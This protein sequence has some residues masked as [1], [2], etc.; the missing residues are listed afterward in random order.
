MSITLVPPTPPQ[1][2]VAKKKRTRAFKIPLLTEMS[3][4]AQ[5][6]YVEQAH[7]EILA[8]RLPTHSELTVKK[9]LLLLPQLKL[10]EP[11]HGS[12][13]LWPTALESELQIMG[14]QLAPPRLR[15]IDASIAREEAGFTVTNEKHDQTLDAGPFDLPPMYVVGSV[16]AQP[17]GYATHLPKTTQ[18]EFLAAQRPIRKYFDVVPKGWGL[19]LYHDQF[20]HLID[21]TEV[22]ERHDPWEAEQERRRAERKAAKAAVA[23]LAEDAPN[24]ALAKA[25]QLILNASM[26]ASLSSVREA[27]RRAQHVPPP[28]TAT[29]AERMLARRIRF[30]SEK[31][32]YNAGILVVADVAPGGEVVD[33]ERLLRLSGLRVLAGMEEELLG[34]KLPV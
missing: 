32:L 23:Q 24:A 7:D 16:T 2:P 31:S 9:A 11:L 10:A 26:P 21:M 20:K 30:E 4:E 28:E 34:L 17:I 22:L 8:A 6:A 29:V 25:F 27:I 5:R 13:P 1:P 15:Q 19:P 12:G 3:P 18:P 14:V 33:P